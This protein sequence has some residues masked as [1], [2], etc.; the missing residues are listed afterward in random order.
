MPTN[1]PKTTVKF[2]IALLKNQAKLWLGEDA[3]GIAAQTILDEDIQTRLNDWLES[4]KTAKE[5][6]NVVEKAQLYLQDPNNCPDKDLRHLFRDMTF[7]DLPTVQAAVLKI[8]QSMD[9]GKLYEV[10]N[11]AFQRDLPNLSSSQHA[12]GARLYTDAM[13]RAVG[14]LEEFVSPILLQTVLDLKKG[15][16]VADKKLDRIIAVLEAKITTQHPL[17]PTPKGDLP[18]GSHLPFPRNQNFTGRVDDL[19][20]LEAALCPPLHSEEGSEVRSIVINQAVTGMG[21]IGKTQLAVEFAYEYGHCFRGVHWLD[22]R[23]PQALDSQIAL[24]GEKMGLA[25][26]PPTLPEQVT[27]TLHTWQRDHPRLLILD[28][29][30]AMEAANEVLARLRHSGLRLLLTSRRADWNAALGLKR[31]P[32]DEFT[33]KESREF[34]R[35]H[36]PSPRGRGD[37]GEVDSDSELDS[38]AVHLGHLPLALELAARYLEKHPHL[39]IREYLVQLEKALEHKSMQNWKAEHKSLTGHDLS[40][41]QTFAQS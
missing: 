24:C 12:E 31:L 40:L 7:G 22:L 30:E 8:P 5:L 32:L 1:L 33:P 6:L 20:K 35:K 16:T 23:N 27:L 28:N 14:S 37:G 21:G 38:L 11:E 36:L 41:L 25:P 9:S 4:D 19:E 18:I 34:L 2:L 10:L 3:A 15:Q 26:W 29:F 13:L 17:S 39:K